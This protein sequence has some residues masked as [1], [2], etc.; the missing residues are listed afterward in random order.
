M[1]YV[2]QGF[3]FCLIAAM[4]FGCAVAALSRKDLAKR[5]SRQEEDDLSGI[6]G[7]RHSINSSSADR[8][9]P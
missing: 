2:L 8:F 5:L 1:S 9:L 3:L 4:V 7:Y 6:E